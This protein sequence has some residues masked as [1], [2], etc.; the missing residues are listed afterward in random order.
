MCVFEYVS[1]I[2]NTHQLMTVQLSCSAVYLY[3]LLDVAS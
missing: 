1:D 2:I 3:V